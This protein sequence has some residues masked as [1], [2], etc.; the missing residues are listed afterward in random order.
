M[1]VEHSTS[2]D[3]RRRWLP[4][5]LVIAGGLGITVGSQLDLFS[6]L[7]L[8]WVGYVPLN[9]ESGLHITAAFPH[10]GSRSYVI[11]LIVLLGSVILVLGGASIKSD[12]HRRSI[13]VGAFATSS[14]VGAHLAYLAVWHG[15][16]PTSFYAAS[17]LDRGYWVYVARPIAGAVIAVVIAFVLRGQGGG[18]SGSGAAQGDIFTEAYEAGK[19]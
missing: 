15:T 8:G 17:G 19:S 18:K 5:T 1:R 11:A 9:T 6:P 16:Q 3:G 7:A 2:G 4:I 13:S 10:F 14:L 12:L